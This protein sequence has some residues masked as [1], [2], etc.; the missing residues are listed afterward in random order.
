M[1]SKRRKKTPQPLT[2]EALVR[3]MVADEKLVRETNEAMRQLREGDGPP[4]IYVRAGSIGAWLDDP[5]RPDPLKIPPLSP[6]EE[7]D[8]AYSRRMEERQDMAEKQGRKPPKLT[9]DALR[10]AMLA[11]EELIAG[12]IDAWNRAEAGEPAYVVTPVAIKAWL[13]DPSR[14]RP[15]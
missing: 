5:S 1:A 10:Q 2:G 14:P 11:D 12:T 7:V 6:E 8:P 15:I 13:N 9:G 3:A 4:A